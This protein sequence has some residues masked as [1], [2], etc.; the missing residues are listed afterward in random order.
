MAFV[1]HEMSIIG[2]EIGYLAFPHQALDGRNIDDTS[3]PFP[4][5][6]DDPNTSRIDIEKRT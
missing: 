4:S 6:A 1:H 5:A 2:H 3:R